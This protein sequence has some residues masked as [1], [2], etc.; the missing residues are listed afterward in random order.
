MRYVHTNII[1][2]N[3]KLLSAFYQKVFDC[4]PV[5]P[6]R[7]LKGEWVDQLTGMK[8]IHVEGE[9]LALPGYE[10]T[11][12]TLEIFSYSQEGKELSKEINRFG[13]SHIAF[14]VEDVDRVLEKVKENGG[15]QI[16][17]VVRTVYPNDVIATMVYATDIEGNIIELQ[18][19]K[20]KE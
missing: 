18:N 3:W 20:K 2:R 5:P 14:G 10:E 4:K 13:Y 11:L 8:G 15:G 19:W 17:E 6:I 16:G 7:D 1:A 12:P 9:H